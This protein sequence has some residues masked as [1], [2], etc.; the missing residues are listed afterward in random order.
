[1]ESLEAGSSIGCDFDDVVLRFKEA[2]ERFL[3]G[4]VVFDY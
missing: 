1:M 3:D 4:T 2:S